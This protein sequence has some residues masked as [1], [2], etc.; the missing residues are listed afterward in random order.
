M[1]NGGSSS[2]SSNANHNKNN[3]RN[4]I[5]KN[6]NTINKIPDIEYFT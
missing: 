5:Y 3:N 2:S 1:N 6:S 4:N